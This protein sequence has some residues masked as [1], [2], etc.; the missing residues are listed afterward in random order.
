MFLLAS[1][2]ALAADLVNNYADRKLIEK[3]SETELSLLHKNEIPSFDRWA[4][5]PYSSELKDLSDY[6][7]YLT[8]GVTAYFAY[9]DVFW[10]DNLMVFSQIMITQSAVAKWTKTI[11]NRYRPFVYDAN[12]SSGKKQERNSQHS[13]YSMHS[14]TVFA[15]STFAYY[16]HSSL[17][18]Q[19][20]TAATLLYTPSVATA[21]LRVVS[22]NHFVS[23]VVAGA[24]VGSGISYLI[25]QNY[26]NKNFN[27]ELGYNSLFINYQF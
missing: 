24:L 20:L 4:W 18:G 15:A 23:D 2:T 8:I 26:L 21:I 12:V 7:A 27:I 22:G 11:T 19:D 6:S 9:D 17:H 1:S 25:C 13:F 16:Y 3:P 5:S 14:S 10:F